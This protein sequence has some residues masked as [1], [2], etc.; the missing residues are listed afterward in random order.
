MEDE[1]SCVP[2]SGTYMGS[3]SLVRFSEENHFQHMQ[4]P[5]LEME[6]R[7]KCWYARKITVHGS[8]MFR[9]QCDT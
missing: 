9:A 4:G 6:E 7:V 3:F 8:I 2:F 5:C 1:E